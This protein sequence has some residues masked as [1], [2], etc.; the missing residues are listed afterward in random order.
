MSAP[1]EKEVGADGGRARSGK[2]REDVK[3]PAHS[4]TCT[5]GLACG[6]RWVRRGST[7]R[8]ALA[9]SGL[10]KPPAFMI[11]TRP[12]APPDLPSPVPAWIGPRRRRWGRPTRWRGHSSVAVLTFHAQQGRTPPPR[13][14]PSSCARSTKAFQD[15]Q[16]V[17]RGRSGLP[18][19]ARALAVV[20][21]AAAANSCA[22]RCAGLCGFR[23]RRGCN[24]CRSIS[25]II[26]QP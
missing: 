13:T 3:A 9:G 6:G 26:L 19:R 24:I 8:L 16:A 1:A 22:V 5:H 23:Q 4:R 21:T 11:E 2:A 18:G 7:V 25:A 10:P 14:A 17:D 20:A 15:K 12:A